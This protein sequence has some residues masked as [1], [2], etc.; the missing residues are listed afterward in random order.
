[1]SSG[2]DS[3]DDIRAEL[4][5]LLG[6]D[7]W[8]VTESAR[9]DAAPILRAAGVLPTDGALIDYVTRLLE[10]D[11]LCRTKF[12]EVTLGSGEK[13]YALNDVDGRGLYVKVMIKRGRHDELWVLSFHVSIHHPGR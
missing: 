10:D 6:Q 8:Q 1:M 7:D 12:H 4:L 9:R 11:V 5:R 3:L 2:G 13:A